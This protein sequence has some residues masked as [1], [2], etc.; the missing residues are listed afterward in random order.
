MARKLLVVDDERTITTILAKIADGLGHV[1]RTCNDSGAAVAVFQEFQPDVVMLDLVMPGTDGIDI[2]REILAADAGARIIVMTGF[3]PGYLR[4]AR[5]VAGFYDHPG[6]SQL[7]KP[8]RRVDVAEAL[9]KAEASG[10]G[11]RAAA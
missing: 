8:F 1:V 3:G 6:V 5:A 10:T 4:L 11:S 7:A 9:A 2:M